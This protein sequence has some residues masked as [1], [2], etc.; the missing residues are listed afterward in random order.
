MKLPEYDNRTHT[1]TVYDDPDHSSS[2]ADAK[3]TIVGM[4][5]TVL[6]F[7]CFGYALYALFLFVRHLFA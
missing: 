4:S 1:T 3:S 5:L 7:A 2:T 6:L